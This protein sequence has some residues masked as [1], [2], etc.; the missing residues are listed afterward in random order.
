MD[1]IFIETP[2]FVRKFDRLATQDEMMALQDELIADPHRG[3][4]V[5]GTGGARKIRMR[6]RGSGKSGGARVIYYFVDL[7]GEV[8]FLDVYVKSGK[9]SLSESEKQS[10]RDFIKETIR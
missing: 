5:Q 9:S 8:W 2:E 10:L 4:L 3:R 7:R 1:I 6:V